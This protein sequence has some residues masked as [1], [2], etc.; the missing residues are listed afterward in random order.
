MVLRKG[1]RGYQVRLLQTKLRNLGYHIGIDSSF[2]NG[3]KSVVKAYQ[4]DNGLK[5]DGI[6]GP[7][8]QRTIKVAQRMK[9][10]EFWISKEIQV[11]KMRR[12]ITKVDLINPKR[13]TVKSMWRSLKTKPKLLINGGLFDMKTGTD[14]NVAY[15][16]KT[17][18]GSGYYSK[19]GLKIDYYG[20][21]SFG[22][23]ESKDIDFLGGSPILMMNGKYVN[24]YPGLDYGFINYKHPR[25]G[26]G[27]N[28]AYMFM[29][30]Y[31]GRSKWRRWYGASLIQFAKVFDD[32]GCTD[33]MNLDGGGSVSVINKVGLYF[34]VGYRK[35]AN[36]L[37]FYQD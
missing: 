13:M 26:V 14:L 23:H 20:K 5:I 11:V 18:F 28:D 27:A 34:K 9:Y 19:L 37:A 12:S 8:S 29:I 1:S 7:M 36:M 25:I 16:D 6:Y 15:N 2:G 32:L 35:V 33:A 3:T 10:Q 31:N 22:P 17:S 24:E 4:K 21:V 30:V